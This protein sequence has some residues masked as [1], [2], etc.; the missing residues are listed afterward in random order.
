MK[1]TDDAIT[2]IVARKVASELGGYLDELDLIAQAQ[3]LPPH[4]KDPYM[5]LTTLIAMTKYKDEVYSDYVQKGFNP[6]IAM[7]KT[8]EHL[9]ELA[10]G[11]KP[12]QLTDSPANVIQFKPKD[13]K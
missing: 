12:K 10:F 7:Q 4:M 1:L 3:P 6:Q 13:S 5:L 8:E 2:L 11:D 9:T